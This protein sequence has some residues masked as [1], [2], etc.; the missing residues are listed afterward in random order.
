LGGP[1]RRILGAGLDWFLGPSSLAFCLSL[2]GD[3]FCAGEMRRQELFG[4]VQRYGR[5]VEDRAIGLED[6]RHPGV[7]SR[8]ASCPAV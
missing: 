2:S 6:V 3:A 5:L 8:A 4:S 1:L 7:M